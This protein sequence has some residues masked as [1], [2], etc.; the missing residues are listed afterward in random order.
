VNLV[1]EALVSSSRKRTIGILPEKRDAKIVT[2]LEDWYLREQRRL[3]FRVG[4]NAYATWVSEVMLQQTQVKTV[5]P[6]F[7]RWMAEFPT[8]QALAAATE[9]QVLALWQGLGYYSRGRNLHVAAKRILA[10][11]SGTLPQDPALLL[12]L[13]GIGRYT[14]GAIASIA[15]DVPAP[16]LD[17]NVIRVLSRL[18]ARRGDPHKR[19]NSAALWD[20][21]RQLVEKSHPARFNQ[22]LMELGALVCTPKHPTCTLCPVLRHCIAGTQGLAEQ[23]PEL[24]KR[25]KTQKRHV[26]LLFATRHGKVLLRQQPEGS[27]HW[28]KLY[29]LPYVETESG[30]AKKR[31]AEARAFAQTL[32]AKAE[33]VATQPVAKLTYPITRFRFDAIAY[34]VTNVPSGSRAGKYHSLAELEQLALPAPHRKIVNQLLA[35]R[36]AR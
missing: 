19:E 27:T 2:L 24:A 26:T 14:A 17:G 4:K 34:E 16:I 12:K 29:V 21:A 36:P 28:E 22:A 10:E 25:P 31:C 6:Y 33:L 11:Y 3:P 9:K 5:V 23:L 15:Y 32:S 1:P 8:V 7:E 13:P 18:D 30:S 20:R 35:R